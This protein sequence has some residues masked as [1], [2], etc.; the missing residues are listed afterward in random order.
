MTGTAH[1]KAI[2]PSRDQI[3]DRIRDTMSR[4]IEKH[5]E[6]DDSRPEAGRMAMF[7]MGEGA[8]SELV[9]SEQ[10]GGRYRF[11]DTNG[12]SVIFEKDNADNGHF[13]RD[14]KYILERLQTAE[15]KP[16]LKSEGQEG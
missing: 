14:L 15:T 7:D 2:E 8:K 11:E 9:V 12:L 4:I 10:G 3:L 1:T 13:V 5:G 16:S 6:S